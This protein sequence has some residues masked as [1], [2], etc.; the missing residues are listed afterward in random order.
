MKKLFI[1]YWIKQSDHYRLRVIQSTRDEWL[2]EA[3][4]KLRV[5]S[6]ITSKKN[7]QWYAA[8]NNNN[9]DPTSDSAEREK[10]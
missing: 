1:D 5:I 7:D 10:I 6:S 3:I 8:W 9:H 2:T 4:T